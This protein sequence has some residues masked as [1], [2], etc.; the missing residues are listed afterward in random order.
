MFRPTRPSHHRENPRNTNIR[1]IP[2]TVSHGS[3]V[4]P[5][6]RR[7]NAARVG[8]AAA[9]QMASVALDSEDKFIVLEPLTFECCSEHVVTAQHAILAAVVAAFLGEQRL[10]EF[11]DLGDLLGIGLASVGMEAGHVLL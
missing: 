5:A 6:I 7:S 4:E 3:T 11:L 9:A 10:I 1:I 8:P 2:A